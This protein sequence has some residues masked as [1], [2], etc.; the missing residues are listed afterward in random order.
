M[1][2]LTPTVDDLFALRAQ[3]LKMREIATRT[4]LSLST[5]SARIGLKVAKPRKAP[6]GQQ[7]KCL[8]CEH[9][10]WSEGAHNRLCNLCRRRSDSPFDT[11]H[12]VN[13]HR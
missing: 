2:T 7:R 12:N 9:T 10:F 3:G 1:S 4:G 13:P 5:V 8:C 6:E 11:A